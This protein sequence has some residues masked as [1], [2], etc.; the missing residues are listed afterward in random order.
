MLRFGHGDPHAPQVRLRIT[1]TTMISIA[2]SA[3]GI[4]RPI[5]SRQRAPAKLAPGVGVAER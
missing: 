2:T 4:S 5:V 3:S 1:A